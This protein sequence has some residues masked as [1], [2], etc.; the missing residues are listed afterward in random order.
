MTKDG[1][2]VCY[3]QLENRMNIVITAWHSDE[4]TSAARFREML[5][6]TLMDM[7]ALCTSAGGAS[8]ASAKL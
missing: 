3:A 1:Y 2:G 7:R 5:S 8:A 4:Q 6:R